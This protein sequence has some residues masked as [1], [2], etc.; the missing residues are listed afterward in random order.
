MIEIA[1]LSWLVWKTLNV[2]RRKGFSDS[3]SLIRQVHGSGA[4]ASP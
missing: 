4:R 2:A 3:Y 1:C